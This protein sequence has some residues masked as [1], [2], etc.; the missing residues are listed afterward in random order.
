MLGIEINKNLLK[1]QFPFQFISSPNDCHGPG[2]DTPNAQT[3]EIGTANFL[4]DPGITGNNILQSHLFDKF[5]LKDSLVVQFSD[6]LTLCVGFAPWISLLC[7]DIPLEVIIL[8]ATTIFRGFA[9]RAAN[10]RVRI[11]SKEDP[12]PEDYFLQPS[13]T[14]IWDVEIGK[15]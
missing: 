9:P 6:D 1:D 5:S 4:F 3:S 12:K 2:D 11:F 10:T 15:G 13:H 8:S 14:G 7:D